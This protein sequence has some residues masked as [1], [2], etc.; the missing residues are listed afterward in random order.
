VPR[1]GIPRQV[2]MLSKPLPPDTITSARAASEHAGAWLSFRSPAA[3]G[4]TSRAVTNYTD[5]AA[6]DFERTGNEALALKRS[7]RAVR[8]QVP[9]ALDRT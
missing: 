3:I 1:F 9:R 5:A 8:R 4:V 6:V 2:L 7:P